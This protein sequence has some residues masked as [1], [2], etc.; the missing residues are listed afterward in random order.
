MVERVEDMNQEIVDF[1]I[2]HYTSLLKIKRNN[3]CENKVLD[4][5]IEETKQRLITYGVDV[6]KFDFLLK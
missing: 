3:S 5:D 2:S 4:D 1:T 6:S